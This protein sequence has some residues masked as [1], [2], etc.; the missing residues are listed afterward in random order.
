GADAGAGGG[1]E[2]DGGGGDKAGGGGGGKTGGGA[3]VAAGTGVLSVGSKPPGC[4][5][6][7]DGKNTGLRTPQREISLKA[8]SHRVTLINNELGI[9]DTFTVE[10][11]ANDTVRAI[12]DY[13]NKVETP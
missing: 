1:D 6:H 4:E 13:M 7:I 3:V 8:G 2:D 11:K 5:I 10:V 12:K 9:R